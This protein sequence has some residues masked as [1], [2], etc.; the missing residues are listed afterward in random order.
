MPQ[1]HQADLQERID[2]WLELA[3]D[4][5]FVI[6][7]DCEVPKELVSLAH[8][9][10]QSPGD[11]G[12]TKEKGKLPKGKLNAEAL[13]VASGVLQKRLLEYPTTLEVCYFPQLNS[14]IANCEIVGGRSVT[15]KFAV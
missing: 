7:T 5:T 6:E 4:D 11:W 14:R 9:L 2:W 1:D 10:L 13:P 3:E 8:L 12:K 15:A